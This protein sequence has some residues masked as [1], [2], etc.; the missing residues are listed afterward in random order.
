MKRLLLVLTISLASFI[1]AGL[2]FLPTSTYQVSAKSL[3]LLPAASGGQKCSKIDA[4][5]ISS[6]GVSLK[7]IRQNGKLIWKKVAP[8][9]TS[10]ISWSDTQVVFGG[11]CGQSLT[12]SRRDKTLKEFQ[13]LALVTT[14]SSRAVIPLNYHRWSK[15]LLF[16]TFN[17]DTKVQS[18]FTLN[19]GVKDSSPSLIVSLPPSAGISDAVIDIM[20]GSVM[21]L[22]YSGG[23]PS[24][25][26]T[27]YL[28][29]GPVQIWN[30]QSAGWFNNGLTFPSEL[31]EST[32][33]QV[34]VAGSNSSSGSWRLDSVTKSSSSSSWFS[35][36]VLVGSGS[37]EAAV[38]Y[39]TLGGDYLAIYTNEKLYICNKFL[40]IRVVNSS[41]CSIVSTSTFEEPRK[42]VWA[43]NPAAGGTTSLW[44]SGSNIFVDPKTLA[45]TPVNLTG[46][47]WGCGMEI[48]SIEEIDL[49]LLPNLKSW[50]LV[51]DTLFR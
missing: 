41:T 26:I 29:S 10:K 4:T 36:N 49:D 50:T 44:V 48:V 45:T 31:I 27:Q 17:C 34:F 25:G 35:S 7:C 9:P 3:T 40:S 6:K 33:G 8:T 43:S 12:Y 47:I 21:A 19:L 13:K 18:L 39:G 42:I 28:S 46:C 37:I 1:A 24:Y 15:T 23:L 32:G 51:G 11:Y 38:L 5:S 14:D 22:T 20:T 2:L 16:Q 30:A